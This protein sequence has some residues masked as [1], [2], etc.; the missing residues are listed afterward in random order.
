MANQDS[1][2]GLDERSGQWNVLTKPPRWDRLGAMKGEDGGVDGLQGE[3]TG[4]L[5]RERFVDTRELSGDVP[6]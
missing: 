6:A 4:T 3:G 1:A 2:Q 5:D